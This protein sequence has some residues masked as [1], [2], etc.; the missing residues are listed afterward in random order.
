MN[1]LIPRPTDITR[2]FWEGL[3][4]RRILI[5]RC[6]ACGGWVFY[7]RRHC[8]HCAAQDLAWTEVSGRAT[9]CTFT[10]ARVPTLPGFAGAE[11]QN[12]AVVTFGEGFNMNTALT[13]VAPDAMRIGMPLRPVFDVLD[14]AGHTRLLFTAG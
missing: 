13:G 4:E 10:I 7:P 14:P 12:L 6:R 5:P 8:T 2:P 1:A 9:L 3:R 11:P